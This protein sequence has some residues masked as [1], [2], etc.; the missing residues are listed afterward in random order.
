MEC[1]SIGSNPLLTLEYYN[2][3]EAIDG[4]TGR[5]MSGIAYLKFILGR[6]S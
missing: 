3:W 6:S 5:T 1:W 4:S 2:P